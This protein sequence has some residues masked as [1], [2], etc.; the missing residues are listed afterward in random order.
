MFKKME[1]KVWEYRP[2]GSLGDRYH[3][4]VVAKTEINAKKKAIEVTGVNWLEFD[5][6]AIETPGFELMKAGDE[7][8]AGT[9]EA[10]GG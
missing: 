8:N 9:D 3:G 6:K 7:E 2:K 4:F 5:V 1:W 10:K